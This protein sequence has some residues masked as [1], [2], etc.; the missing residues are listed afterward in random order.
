MHRTERV[1]EEP[2]YTLKSSGSEE[3]VKGAPDTDG[4]QRAP[5]VARRTPA[6]QA[7]FCRSP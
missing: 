3:G 4:W 1:R 7:V 5:A 2:V 6:A